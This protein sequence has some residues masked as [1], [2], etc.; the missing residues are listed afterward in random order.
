[1]FFTS[2]MMA[3]ERLAPTAVFRLPAFCTY[4]LC[5]ILL[6]SGWAFMASYA[7]DLA[8]PAKV[9]KGFLGSSFWLVKLHAGASAATALGAITWLVFGRSIYAASWIY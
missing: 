5:A 9:A 6:L 7:S 1:M 4:V 2:V 3:M 8:D